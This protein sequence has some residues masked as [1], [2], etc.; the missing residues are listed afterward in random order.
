[1]PTQQLT[2]S[3]KPQAL[4]AMKQENNGKECEFDITTTS[5]LRLLPVAFGSHRTIGNEK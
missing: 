5:Q 2:P 3:P 1:M 4:L